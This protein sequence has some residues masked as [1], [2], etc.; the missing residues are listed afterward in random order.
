MAEE[1]G[2]PGS[3]N[4]SGNSP[5][6]PAPAVYIPVNHQ[7]QTFVGDPISANDP[8]W[9]EWVGSLSAAI[10]AWRTPDDQ[11]A[12]LAL[13]YLGGVAR[14]EVLVLE[15]AKRTTLKGVLDH[16]E[17]IY[18][19]HT[20]LVK[21][22]GEFYAR[23][24]Q[25]DESIRQ[26]SLCLEELLRRVA[27]RYPQALPNADRTLRDK[28]VD[29]I[30]SH[31]IRMELKK[32]VRKRDG[33]TFPQVKAEALELEKATRINGTEDV[34]G[35][36]LQQ[37][38]APTTSTQDPASLTGM[39]MGFQ[40]WQRTM[41][42]AFS[43]MQQQMQQLQVTVA[44]AM[45]TPRAQPPVGR[46]MTDKFTEDGRPICR[47]CNRPGHIARYCREPRNPPRNPPQNLSADAATSTPPPTPANPNEST[48]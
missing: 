3:S 25:R 42:A 43:N 12:E 6:T 7:I 28:F 16:L 23:C 10:K 36:G 13:R 26:Y 29:G 24:Q 5:P 44:M 41:E 39:G 9:E 27:L 11:Q 21:L 46:R 40:E 31:T 20:P 18:G 14:R 15:E 1:E 34:I 33:I 8:S 35:V 4:G 37:I 19:D 38:G 48:P 45:S 32:E 47:N 17:A 2:T 30:K 22:M